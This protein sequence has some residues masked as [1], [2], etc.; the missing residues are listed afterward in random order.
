LVQSHGDLQ[1]FGSPQNFRGMIATYAIVALHWPS[2][3]EKWRD[4]DS[5]IHLE[6]P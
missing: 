1:Q 3:E 6:P 2:M 4:S 5:F